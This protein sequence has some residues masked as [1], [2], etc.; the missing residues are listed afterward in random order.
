MTWIIDCWNNKTDLSVI[1]ILYETLIYLIVILS[2]VGVFI[3]HK[4]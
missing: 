3:G 4:S 1:H 2:Y